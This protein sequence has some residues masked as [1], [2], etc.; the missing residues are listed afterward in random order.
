VKQT[1]ESLIND[2][3]TFGR[4][5]TWPRLDQVVVQRLVR[6][7]LVVMNGVVRKHPLQM[8]VTKQDQLA[9]ALALH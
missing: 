9:Q 5:V 4:R 3:L 2:D 7:V 6:A 1:A 8:A